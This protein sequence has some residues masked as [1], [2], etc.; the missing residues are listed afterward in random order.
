MAKDRHV[1]RDEEIDGGDDTTLPAHRAPAVTRAAT[2]LRLLANERGDLGVSEIARRVG[3]VP[4]T[5][6]HVLRALVGEGLVSFDEEKKSYRTAAGLLTLVRTAIANGT[7]TR[8]VQPVLDNLAQKHP[9][10]AI[11]LELDRQDRMIVVAIARSDAAISLHV[12][13]GSR[14]PSFISA[15]GRCFAA[16]SGLDKLQLKERF[17]V[18]RWEKAPR[19]EGWYQEVERARAD[20]TAT[21]FGN[22]VRGLTVVAASLPQSSDG[23]QR[24]IAV[25]GFEHQLTERS[26]K[27]IRMTLLE[28]VREVARL[29][30]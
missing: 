5:C 10:T 21:D 22:F 23:I 29:I 20:K 3:L 17:N 8:A 6:L 1:E 14:F 12:D 26:L 18:L 25:V 27:G 15:S 24:G 16:E 2:I 30:D 7:F 11:A 9:V 19:F 4:S 28:A 13:I